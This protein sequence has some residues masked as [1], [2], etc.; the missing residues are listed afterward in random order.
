MSG[1]RNVSVC[2]GHELANALYTIHLSLSHWEF[3]RLVFGVTNYDENAVV[4]I[5]I[6]GV[7]LVIKENLGTL[8]IK[9]LPRWFHQWGKSQPNS[10]ICSNWSTP[11]MML[12]VNA[13]MGLSQSIKCMAYT[14]EGGCPLENKLLVQSSAFKWTIICTIRIALEIQDQRSSTLRVSLFTELKMWGWRFLRPR[15]IRLECWRRI[16]TLG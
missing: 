4:R 16:A 1:K 13:Q 7:L 8:K 11:I 3:S 5:A 10:G 12:R 9:L 6:A 2:S 14:N 15:R